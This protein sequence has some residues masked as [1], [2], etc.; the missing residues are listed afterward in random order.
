MTHAHPSNRPLP[1]PRWRWALCCALLLLLLPSAD[2][3]AGPP[4]V[5]GLFYGNGD[6]QKYIPYLTS[7]GGSVQYVYFDALTNNLY[8]ALVVDHSVNDLVCAPNEGG[9]QNAN[10]YVKSAGWGNHRDCKR[11]SDSEYASWTLACTLGDEEKTWNWQ[12]ALGCAITGGANPSNWVSDESCGPS[13]GGGPWPQSIVSSTSWVHNVNAFQS[14]PSPAWDMYV[15][16]DGTAN[17]KSPF[18]SS[19][20]NDVTV[21]P[22]YPTYSP[23]HEWEWSMVY[24]WS[25]DLGPGGVD[26]GNEAIYFITGESHHSPAKS[27][28]EDDVFPP[29]DDGEQLFFLDFGALPEVYGTLLADDGA[30]HLVTVEGPRLGTLIQIET[31]GIPTADASGEGNEVDGVTVIVN[32]DWVPSSTQT[33]QVE[34]TNVHTGDGLVLLGAWFDWNNGGDFADPGEF[35][36][37]TLGEGIHDLD[38]VVG[39]DFDWENDDLYAR[40]R[41]FSSEAAAPDGTLTQADWIGLASDGEVE[42]YFFPAGTLPV[43]LNAFSSEA[44]GSSVTVRW[45]TA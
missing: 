2:A 14:N 24:E 44:A 45:Q 1:I 9:G 10:L 39:A 20:P 18:L 22:G 15:H 6:D 13:Q 29:P 38:I 26:C 17:W 31:D 23:D 7:V 32:E 16:G 21:V 30:R 12:Q 27:G 40:F 19:D 28:P 11:A 5:N 33:I 36:S 41:V 34:I 25:V 3:A 42:D 43:K 8:V 4:T 35:F 37:W